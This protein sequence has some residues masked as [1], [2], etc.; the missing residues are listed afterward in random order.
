MEAP[1]RPW[2]FS[3]MVAAGVNGATPAG[4]A[5]VE[6]LLYAHGGILRRT[7][8]SLVTNVGGVVAAYLPVGAVGPA[9]L[10]EAAD[11]ITLQAGVLHTS[12]GWMGH[13]A[14]AVSVRFLADIV[15]G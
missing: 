2:V 15:G 6:A 4:D 13:T 3:G 11:L 1:T 9:A 8:S 7:G 14:L 12:R 10:V 5:D